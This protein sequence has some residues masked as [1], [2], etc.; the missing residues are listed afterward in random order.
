[1]ELYISRNTEDSVILLERETC[2][3]GIIVV[4][5]IYKSCHLLH[6]IDIES[7]YCVSTCGA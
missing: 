2:M 4:C 5:H 6:E 7:S 3:P 1:M